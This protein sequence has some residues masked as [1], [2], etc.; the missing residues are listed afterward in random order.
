MEEDQ[1]SEGS[2]GNLLLMVDKALSNG[3]AYVELKETLFQVW[4]DADQECNREKIC[5]EGYLKLAAA[6]LTKMKGRH[7]R[8]LEL[9]FF[10]GGLTYNLS[11][12]LP[13]SRLVRQAFID[14]GVYD[15]LPYMMSTNDVDANQ[16]KAGV[17]AAFAAC[18]GNKKVQTNDISSQM[19]CN[20]LSACIDDRN[21]CGTHWSKEEVLEAIAALCHNA[22]NCSVVIQSNAAPNILACLG[23][24]DDGKTV[25]AAAKSLARLAASESGRSW[26]H[27]RQTEWMP[28]LDR[29]QNDDDVVTRSSVLSVMCAIDPHQPRI[30]EAFARALE[31]G[32][33]R[34]NRSQIFLVGMGRAGKTSFLNAMRQREFE[35]TPSTVGMDSMTLQIA[36][37]SSGKGWLSTC[38]T[39]V[40]G[41]EAQARAEL[42]AAIAAGRDAVS[43]GLSVIDALAREAG[44]GSSCEARGVP[45]RTAAAVTVAANETH[46]EERGD[47]AGAADEA[48]RLMDQDLVLHCMRD[49]GTDNEITFEV[50]DFGGEYPPAN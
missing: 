42:T 16:F 15:C 30:T 2:V 8:Q 47:T 32:S 48:G 25:Q 45:E 10:A 27:Q 12:S 3:A 1:E 46:R 36:S 21:F 28:I 20:C 43:T 31:L 17:I 4:N 40:H 41:E 23:E 29:L 35:D 33:K 50:W 44:D 19:M 18:G 11:R 22:Q 13:Y 38:D 9:R 6:L 26:L 5:K 24:S 14:S 7:Q 49:E 37:L 39:D 34:W